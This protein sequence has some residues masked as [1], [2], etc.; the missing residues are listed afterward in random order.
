MKTTRLITNIIS[1][2]LFAVIMFQSC[3]AGV[4]N[5][6][7][8]NDSLSGT[9]GV[10]LAFAM[11]IAGIVGIA[12]RKNVGGMLTSGFFYLISSLLAFAYVGDFSDLAIW[13]TVSLIFSAIQFIG[14]IVINHSEEDQFLQKLNVTLSILIIISTIAISTVGIHNAWY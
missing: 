3:A 12:A 11:L 10:I 6:I 5:S 7:D 2:V 4:V 13:A 1:I 14:Y 8:N 9:A